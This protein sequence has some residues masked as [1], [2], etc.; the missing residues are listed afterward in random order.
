MANRFALVGVSLAPIPVGFLVEPWLPLGHWGWG[1]VAV[2][3]CLPALITFRRAIWSFIVHRGMVKSLW[4]RRDGAAG[5]APEQA[6]DFSDYDVP[7]RDAIE[8]V[9]AM[10]A[11]TF[12]NSGDADRQAFE[13]LHKEM[14]ADRLPVI[15]ALGDFN[16]PERV[17]A[18]KCRELKPRPVIVPR[19]PTSPNGMLFA[20][21]DETR[22]DVTP[23]V[24][25]SDPLGFTGLRVR[26]ADLYRKWPRNDP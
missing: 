21:V 4:R 17:S 12:N 25:R 1:V 23:L 10:S 3:C 24:E 15:G 19:N 9:V 16:A 6:D 2:S 8:H 14:C 20:L 11:H 7:V 22:I 13:A 26:S 5:V 18:R